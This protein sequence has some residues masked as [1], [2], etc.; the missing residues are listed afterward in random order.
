MP[1][2]RND[3][4]FNTCPDYASA[5]LVNT[6]AQLINENV[7]E[8]QAIQLLRYIWLANNEADKALWQQQ[9]ADDREQ[10]EHAQRLEEDE[11]QRADQERADE[12]EATRKEERKKN[13]HKYTPILATGIPDDP[14]ITPCSYAL[15]KLDKGEY[16]ELWYFTNDGLDEA[17]TKKTIDD[18]AMVLSTLV[19][20]SMAWISSASA[21]N[22]RSVVNDE[23][24][25]FKEFCQAC[26]R[27]LVAL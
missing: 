22:A 21:R 19:D 15:H 7:N 1:R 25:P 23:N 17:S 9:L 13:K 14:S 10:Q 4:N 16:V 12:E 6:R 3:P 27:F 11:Q 18:D 24:L 20:G 26:P 5:N 2:I 8:E